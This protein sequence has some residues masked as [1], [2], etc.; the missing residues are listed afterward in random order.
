MSGPVEPA[1]LAGDGAAPE[2]AE[3]PVP[4]IALRF[5]GPGLA[6]CTIELGRVTPGQVM[7]AAWFLD[8]YAR[9]LRAQAVAAGPQLVRPGPADVTRLHPRR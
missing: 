9:E 3:A 8:A 6:D 2:A 5:A 7:A 1:T 4:S